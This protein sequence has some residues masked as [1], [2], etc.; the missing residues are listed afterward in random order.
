MGEI[1][2]FTCSH[3]DYDEKMS[4]GVG[5]HWDLKKIFN[6]IVEDVKRGKHGEDWKKELKKE[7]SLVVNISDEIYICPACGYF[8]TS[9]NLSL[10]K[11]VEKMKCP[12]FRRRERY[13]T[14]LTL[15]TNPNYQLYKVYPHLCAKCNEQMIVRNSRKEDVLPTCPKCGEKGELFIDTLWD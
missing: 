11:P 4:I 8:T 2:R 6:G 12:A 7:P 10:Y 15:E 5:M 13:G 14:D 3:C 1:I 9:L